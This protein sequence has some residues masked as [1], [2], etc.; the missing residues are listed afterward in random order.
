MKITG[1]L[2]KAERLKRDLSVQD[3]AYA[4]KLNSRTI[5]AIEGGDLDQ[6]PAKTFIRGFVKS[7]ADYLKI[8]SENVLRQF[9]E[10]MGSTRPIPKRPPPVATDQVTTQKIEQK[11]PERVV[12]ESKFSKN[13]FLAVVTV[14]GLLVMIAVVNNKINDYK[15][16]TVEALQATTPPL[17]P[18]TEPAISTIQSPS[19]ETAP[20][21]SEAVATPTTPS[22]TGLPAQA[23]AVPTQEPVAPKNVAP[24]FAQAPPSPG[25]PV[26]LL[27]EAKKEV[28]I[29]Y[30]KGNSTQFTTLRMLPQTF[31]IIRSQSGLHL[32]TQ[33]GSAIH[34][35]VNGVLK[36]SAAN[37]STPTVLSF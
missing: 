34:L 7:Y 37:S 11:T 36:G 30:A 22:A 15:N 5:T 10:E 3:V 26:E 24:S 29:E 13:H 35:T 23:V 31:Q 8:N 16:E 27:I 28:T 33:D 20:I 17:P 21:S 19:A 12:I 4:L 32:R 1:E 25:K 14:V 18:S 6:L 2:L 9:Q